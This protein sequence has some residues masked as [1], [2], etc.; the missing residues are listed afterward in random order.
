[1]TEDL[2][3][4]KILNLQTQAASDQGLGPNE[5]Q[6]LADLQQ[7]LTDLS[8]AAT[9][10]AEAT[11]ASLPTGVTQDNLS[12]FVETDADGNPIVKVDATTNQQYYDIREDLAGGE[13]TDRRLGLEG[14]N[15][16][17]TS[18]QLTTRADAREKGFQGDMR[19]ELVSNFVTD[20]A[21]RRGLVDPFGFQSA[22]GQTKDIIDDPAGTMPAGATYTPE[23]LDASAPGTTLQADQFQLGQQQVV[24]TALAQAQNATQIAEKAAREYN[25]TTAFNQVSQQNMQAEQIN[26]DIRMIQAQQAEVEERSTVRGQLGMLMQ[27]FQGDQVPAWASASVR[28]AEQI[29]AARGLGAST[30][31]GRSVAQAVMEAA[32]PI[33]QQDA[34][35]FAQFQQLNLNNR[36]QAELQNA[37]NLLTVDIKNLD[38]RQQTA[39]LNTQNRVQALFTDQSEINTSRK[40]NAASANQ[41]Q[42]FFSG[43]QQQVNLQ[44]AAQ[45]TAISQFN[46]GAK[47]AV[48]QFNAQTANQRDMFNVQNKVAIEQANAVWRRAVNTANTAAVNAKNQ[49]DAVN[50]LNRSNTALNNYMMVYRDNAD[51]NFQAGQNAEDRAMNTAIASLRA[52][53][54]SGKSPG[55]FDIAAPILGSML[56]NWAATAAGG[57]AIGNVIGRIPIIGNLIK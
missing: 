51:Y 2:I 42:Q 12:R 45:Q 46:A 27:D 26:R 36:Q 14:V 29:M 23:M 30:I 3:R 56:S 39:V 19:D 24:D 40:I 55:F 25:A 52:G 1:M 8:T 50:V 4:A 9:Q 10:Q 49:F 57:T 31:A 6:E 17:V 16:G 54:G 33:A 43:L 32:L 5:E 28:K 18:E 35:T 11:A 41:T 15:T 21:G 47:N 48:A 53:S 22:L 34:S 13:I 20:D 7:Q 38:T 44:N 37:A